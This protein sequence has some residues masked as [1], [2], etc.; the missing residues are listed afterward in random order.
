MDRL[1]DFYRAFN[2]LPFV[3]RR[4][5]YCVLFLLF[6]AYG[7]HVGRTDPYAGGNLGY[8][9]MGGFIWASGLWYPLWI[10]LRLIIFFRTP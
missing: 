9:G 7:V 8:I 6:A 10:L 3:A 4:A 1:P 2:R 5:I